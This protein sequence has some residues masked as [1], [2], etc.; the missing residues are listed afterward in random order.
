MPSHPSITRRSSCS[1]A[2]L[3]GPASLVTHWRFQLCFAHLHEPGTRNAFHANAQREV[4]SRKERRKRASLVCCEA[5]NYS[6][7][8]SDRLR[9]QWIRFPKL[10]EQRSSACRSAVT[11]IERQSTRFLMRVS[12]AT[13]VLPWTGDRS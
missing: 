11:M 12:S 9:I 13:S 6:Q 7:L 8:K 4:G 10:H 5:L 3:F 1:G 2:F